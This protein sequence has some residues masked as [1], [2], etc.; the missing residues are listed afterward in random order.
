LTEFLQ[1]GKV[2]DK[3]HA[4]HAFRAALATVPPPDL[5][6]ADYHMPPF[7]AAEALALLR[8]EN[9]NIPLI[10]LT[11]TLTDDRT[12][13]LLEAGAADYVLKDRMAR[14]APAVLRVLEERRHAQAL[15]QVAAQAL[16]QREQIDQLHQLRDNRLH[17]G[18]TRECD[19]LE[20]LLFGC[21]QAIVVDTRPT[22]EEGQRVAVFYGGGMDKSLAHLFS[23][24]DL[25]SEQRSL[26]L[27][28]GGV[29][30]TRPYE[31]LHQ[32]GSDLYF[33]RQSTAPPKYAREEERV[34]VL[35][36]HG[37]LDAEYEQSLHEITRL[38][39]DLCE[40]PIA[41]IA[42]MDGG[43]QWFKSAVGMPGGRETPLDI[44][45]CA[46]A[47]HHPHH[48]HQPGLMGVMGVTVVPDTLKDKRFSRN[49]LVTGE[50]HPRFYAGVLLESSD[51]Y[52]LGTLC[53]LDYKPR[54]GGLSEMQMRAL[55]VL[56]HQV[57]TQLEMRLLAG[58]QPKHDMRQH[59]KRWALEKASVA[60]TELRSTEGKLRAG[61][62][63]GRRL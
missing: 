20:R 4:E 13:A 27:R 19:A 43:Q 61:G 30:V 44:P 6:L 56:A 63:Q 29:D 32:P 8:C 23:R 58:Q 16:E 31:L 12:A 38:A 11:G 18:V 46:H 54:Y 35:D 40:V 57:M 49:P 28:G 1:L 37:I 60:E 41:V 22:A 50:P 45:I 15:Q 14:L 9:L 25:L 52:P 21:E 3:A 10:V 17:E 55:L 5:I 62:V 51:G 2:A 39:A 7:G 26:L 42:F 36:H 59:D 34:T 53:V 47:I 48:P 33:I 24:P